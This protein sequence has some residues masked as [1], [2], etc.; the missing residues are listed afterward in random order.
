MLVRLGKGWCHK[1]T[2]INYVH[3]L[4]PDHSDLYKYM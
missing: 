3:A 4:I 1:I 2:L